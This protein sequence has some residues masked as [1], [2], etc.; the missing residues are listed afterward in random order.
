MALG[1]RHFMLY[2]FCHVYW[3]PCSAS[4][5]DDTTT[6]DPV[7]WRHPQNVPTKRV[8]REKHL[9]F[10]HNITDVYNYFIVHHINL[11]L[12]WGQLD[13]T[14]QCWA[15]QWGCV[16]RTPN[17]WENS[18]KRIDQWEN[19]IELSDHSEENA[20]LAIP[21][22][23]DTIEAVSLQVIE[24]FK[25]DVLPS[26][27]I[28]EQ[29]ENIIT[30]INQSEE[31][32]GRIDQSEAGIYLGMDCSVILM[33]PTPEIRINWNHFLKCSFRASI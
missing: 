2:G 32:I 15:C 27:C 23:L 13:G 17:Q 10:L 18:I 21:V 3:I 28:A 11:H 9:I 6:Y 14:Q 29:W 8:L 4:Y 7:S 24:T 25:G 19:L 16:C 1:F 31:S 20:Y 22:P 26:D 12:Q 33:V 30:K 5:A